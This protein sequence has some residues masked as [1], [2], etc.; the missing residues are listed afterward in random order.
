VRRERL[1]DF[2]DRAFALDLL[3]HKHVLVAPGC[4]FN[5]PYSTHFRVTNLPEPPVL[6]DVFARIEAQLA[7]YAQTAASRAGAPPLKVV[8]RP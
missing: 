7:V 4:S 8:A 1:P 5:A 2:D 3:E 6:Q